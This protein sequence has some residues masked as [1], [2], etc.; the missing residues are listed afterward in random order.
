MWIILYTT[1]EVQVYNYLFVWLIEQKYWTWLKGFRNIEKCKV[2]IIWYID[3]QT[4][5]LQFFFTISR[6]KSFEALEISKMS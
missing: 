4:K 2:G 3:L 5:L 6:R 1:I